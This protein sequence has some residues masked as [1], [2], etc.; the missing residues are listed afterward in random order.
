V[1]RAPGGRSRRWARRAYAALAAQLAPGEQ[2]LTADNRDDQP[3]GAA[4]AHPALTAGPGEPE[5]DLAGGRPPRPLPV[6]RALLQQFLEQNDVRWSD[7]PSN[8]D[9][10]FDRNYLRQR[11]VPSACARQR[12]QRR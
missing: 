7:D 11:V 1:P 2:L 9:E 3:D 5:V 4:A 10:R 8:L 12:W 6:P